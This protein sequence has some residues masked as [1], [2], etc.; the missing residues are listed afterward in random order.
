MTTPPSFD[1]EKL[2]PGFEFLKNLGQMK[3]PSSLPSA[4]S[5]VAPTLDPKELD[6][7]IQE[8]KTVQFWL[9]QNSKA[10]DATI[11]ALEVQKMTLSTLQGMNFNMKDLS[12]SLR[13][14]ANA[15]RFNEPT[16]GEKRESVKPNKTT[17]SFAKDKPI[18]EP[19]A[20][21]RPK[22]AKPRPNTNLNSGAIDP[23]A[24]WDSLGA[25]FQ[26]IAQKTVHEMQKH[27]AQNKELHSA[28]ATQPTSPT[29][30]P[31]AAKKRYPATTKKSTTKATVPKKTTLKK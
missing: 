12:E 8:L 31:Q 11:Q 30:S 1:F 26:Q 7:K 23:K 16:D 6:K 27:A 28:K 15:W 22:K 24:W 10:L 29:K 18:E 25:Q 2:V 5:W 20:K 14:N 4:A 3:A 21:P 17:Y 19:V 9:N 13:S